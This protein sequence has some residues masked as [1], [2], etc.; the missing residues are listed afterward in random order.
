ML[1]E[2]FSVIFKHR[3]YVILRENFCPVPILKRQFFQEKEEGQVVLV[4]N[5]AHFRSGDLL[6]FFGHERTGELDLQFV[7][8]RNFE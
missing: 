3:G 2:T 7:A 6:V 5:K 4:L 1:N 8:C